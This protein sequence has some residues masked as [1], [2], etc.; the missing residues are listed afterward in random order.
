[1]RNLPES[2]EKH[3]RLLHCEANV[4]ELEE[5]DD[6]HSTS[7]TS[8]PSSGVPHG[9]TCAGLSQ[10]PTGNQGGPGQLRLPEGEMLTSR[11]SK[12]QETNAQQ[13]F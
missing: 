1:M 6:P 8:K 7:R 11:G 9:H 4:S 3:T 12:K 13:G 2:P 10:T 5:K